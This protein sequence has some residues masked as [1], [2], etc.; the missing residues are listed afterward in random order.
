MNGRV[1]VKLGG[2][3]AGSAH[4][5][6][7]LSAIAGA[8]GQAVLV[9]GGGP[10]ADAVREAQPAMGYGDRAAHAMALLAMDQMALALADLEPRLKPAST[11]A[12]LEALASAGMA[13]V[14]RPGA[15]ALSAGDIEA[16]WAMTSDSLACWLAGR[17]GA[18]RLL[19]VKHAPARERSAEDLARAGIVDGAMPG[20]LARTGAEAWLACPE[21]A[22]ALPA[23]LAGERPPGFAPIRLAVHA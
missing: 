12:E 13:P 17:L 11:L 21:A 20:M 23:F 22:D 10:F 9:P 3:F 6:P 18:G 5:R 19:L 1:V 4:L 7:W 2:S 16:S 15:V 8:A 14:W